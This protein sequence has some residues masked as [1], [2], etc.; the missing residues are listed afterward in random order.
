MFTNKLRAAIVA[1]AAVGALAIPASAFATNPVIWHTQQGSSG[2]SQPTDTDNYTLANGNRVVRTY[3]TNGISYADTDQDLVYGNQTW[4]VDL[5][6]YT[7]KY[8][9]LTDPPSG[10]G[11]QWRFVR[12]YASP[13]HQ[14]SGTERVALYNTANH[15]YLADGNETFGVD[16][17]WSSTPRF[18]WQVATGQSTVGGV[19]GSFTELYNTT[20]QAY[21]I[22]G[23]ETW[24]VDLVWL[25]APFSL[26]NYYSPPQTLAQQYIGSISGVLK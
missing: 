6:W 16:L 2:T 10:P 8:A 24:G 22:D 12:Q 25:H 4:G 23:H 17:V 11:P 9:D 13:F 7:P 21:L 20:E 14:I 26:P 15:Q 1:T 5:N 19:T 18:E 3:A